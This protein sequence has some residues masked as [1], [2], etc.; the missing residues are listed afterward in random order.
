[1][2]I[3]VI[4]D[5]HSN[6]EAF[7]EVLKDIDGSDVDKI[8]SLGDNIGYGPEPERVVRLVQE[9]SIISV[10]G[11]HELALASSLYA[12][13]MN[14]KTQKS[15]Q[16]TESL[17]SEET[18][19]YCKLLPSHLIEEDAR[20]VHGSPPDSETIYMFNPTSTWLK[21]IF[22]SFK[23]RL[24]FIGHTH[25]LSLFE[26]N[27]DSGTQTKLEKGNA[28]LSSDK[29]YIINVGSVGQPRD[30][31]NN[32]KYVIWHKDE[33]RIE[34]RYIP[35]DIEVTAN[36]ILDLGFPSFNATRLY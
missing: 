15:L 24:C 20:F 6:L 7:Q 23:E 28:T 36:R 29:R 11:N 13:R 8:I 19:D 25:N 10:K 26:F 1:M 2:K 22:L 17:I 12:N 27:G 32:A 4:S 9:R 5:I 21:E 3:A 30:G 16:I 35:Y 34:I 33:D 18:A 14:K 31:N